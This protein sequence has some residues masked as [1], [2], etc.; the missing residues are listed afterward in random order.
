MAFGFFTVVSS[1]DRRILATGQPLATFHSPAKKKTGAGESPHRV[2]YP[3]VRGR[4]VPRSPSEPE[5][6][7]LSNRRRGAAA[8]PFIL[9][10]VPPD[11]METDEISRAETGDASGDLEDPFGTQGG[12]EIS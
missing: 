1:P 7:P 9:E 6:S 2:M 12:D 8:S 3:R 10:E 5:I 4:K 11:G